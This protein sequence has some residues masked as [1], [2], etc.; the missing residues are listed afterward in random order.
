MGDVP[1]TG[2]RPHPS[3]A[4]DTIELFWA[5]DFLRYWPLLSAEDRAGFVELMGWCKQLRIAQ[6][7]AEDEAEDEKSTRRW[8]IGAAIAAAGLIFT[9][10]N[11]LVEYSVYAGAKP[12]APQKVIVQFPDGQQV[13][14][15]P[16]PTISPGGSIE[17]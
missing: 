12:T 16:M 6:K 9:G 17:P 1:E 8:K 5:R 3:S 2:Y 4:L 11:A 15:T 14:V 13:T 10:L 7:K